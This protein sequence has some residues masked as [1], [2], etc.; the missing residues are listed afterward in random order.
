MS[1]IASRTTSPATTSQIVTICVVLNP[2]TLV[3]VSTCVMPAKIAAKNETI[4]VTLRVDAEI[5]SP[6][7]VSF[8]NTDLNQSIVF[9][10]LRCRD[11]PIDSVSSKLDD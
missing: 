9:H 4:F 5:T 8:E 2:T 11:S 7:D 3:E 10:Q 6:G 1:V